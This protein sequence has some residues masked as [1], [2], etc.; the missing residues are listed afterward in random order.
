[1]SGR[2]IRKTK[3]Y[4]VAGGGGRVRGFFSAGLEGWTL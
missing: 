3:G 1:M 2:A 4:G